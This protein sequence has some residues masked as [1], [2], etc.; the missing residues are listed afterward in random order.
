MAQIKLENIDLSFGKKAV[1]K[2][3]SFDIE[4][5]D[6][7]A[8]TGESGSGKST[9][10]NIIG[11]LLEPNHGKRVHF[12]QENI[13][14]GS[15]HARKVLRDKMGYLFQNY[16]LLDEETVFD[17]M[18]LAIRYSKVKDKSFA[19]KDALAEVGLHGLDKQKVYTLSGGEQQRLS[20][21]RLLVKP[22]DVILADE[23]TGNLDEH[24]GEMIMGI[25]RK[26]NEQ[27]KTIIM[28]TH[29]KDLLHYFGKRVELNNNT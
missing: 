6:M 1:L 10:L 24:N 15:S 2:N 11:L 19:I 8:I 7:V 18:K 14:I 13:A 21:A 28:V 16:A 12:G 3:F 9:L 22:C 17:N 20:L 23:P 29:D 27:G 4:P 5:G 25:L 26:L